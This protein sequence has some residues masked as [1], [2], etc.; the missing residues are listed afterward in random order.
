[1]WSNYYTPLILTSSSSLWVWGSSVILEKTFSHIKEN[2]S[3]QYSTH[4]VPWPDRSITHTS[5][6]CVFVEPKIL[7]PK[8]IVSKLFSLLPNENDLERFE[9]TSSQILC[10][11]FPRNNPWIILISEREERERDREWSSDRER[12]STHMYTRALFLTLTNESNETHT[13]Q[14][15][16]GLVRDILEV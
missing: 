12:D 1:M 15:H 3:D 6:W 14:T 7:E 9:M 13:T 2:E 5:C 10:W 4:N 11:H 8:I 16:R